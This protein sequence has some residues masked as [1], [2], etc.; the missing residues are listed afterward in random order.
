MKN[1]YDFVWPVENYT[2]KI[3]NGIKIMFQLRHWLTFTKNQMRDH[4]I[5]GYPWLSNPDDKQIKLL[6]KIILTAIQKLVQKG[7]VKKVH[8]AL[9]VDSQWQWAAGVDAQVY[10]DVTGDANVAKTI[11]AQ[12]AITRR[13]L[14][15]KTLWRLNHT[16]PV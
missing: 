7:L 13:A 4:V 16:Q 2:D 6:D 15:G 11:E 3:H 5:K 1:K 10:V 12:K 9:T 14:G 8:S